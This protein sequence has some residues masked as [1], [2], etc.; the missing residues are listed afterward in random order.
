MTAVIIAR[1][2]RPGVIGRVTELH[3]VYYHRE[4]GFGLYFEAKVAAELAAFFG[5]CDD[6]RDAFWAALVDG[7]LEGAITIDRSEAAAGGAHLRWF[8]VSDAL[9]GKG[10]GSRLIE[11]AMDFCRR[12]GYPEV[13]LWTFEGLGA[14]RH[15]YEKHGFVLVEEQPG[16][17]WGMTVKEQR[18]VWRPLPGE[19]P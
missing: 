1:G 11:T 14:A 5:R 16:D 4:W 7:R 9:R 10:A 3:A 12:K 13:Y 17:G 15:L 8:I 19:A 2:Y 6:S 18:F